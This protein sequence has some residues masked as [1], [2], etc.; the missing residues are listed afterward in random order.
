[1]VQHGRSSVF[2]ALAYISGGLG[3]FLVV[4]HQASQLFR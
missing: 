4:M 2:K 3:F 1:M